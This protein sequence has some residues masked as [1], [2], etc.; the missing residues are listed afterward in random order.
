MTA[1]ITYIE[2]MLLKDFGLTEKELEDRLLNGLRDALNDE[3]NSLNKYTFT[4]GETLSREEILGDLRAFW[5]PI[6][7]KEYENQTRHCHIGSIMGV[8]H[9]YEAIFFNID[10]NKFIDMVIEHYSMNIVEGCSED[11]F[12]GKA[13]ESFLM[14]H[15][16][17]K[18]KVNIKL[19]VQLAKD[20][21]DFK[22]RILTL[23]KDNITYWQRTANGGQTGIS[24]DGFHS[25]FDGSLYADR[26]RVDCVE[27]DSV[28]TSKNKEVFSRTLGRNNYWGT[29]YDYLLK[30]CGATL[31]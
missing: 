30:E 13:C 17:D 27:Y 1:D 19:E 21:K 10:Y 15:F 16:E 18:E 12:C 9:K 5:I 4:K 28:A 14:I 31:F 23:M 20:E 25:W 11:D 22:H 2:E 6:E 26:F 3:E 8:T 7:V 24:S 29:L